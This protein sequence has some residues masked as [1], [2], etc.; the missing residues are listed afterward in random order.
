[1]STLV[2]RRRRD[3]F[4]D[5]DAL[6]RTA[7][8]PVTRS[9]GFSPAAEVSRDGEDAV[10]RIELPGLDAERDITV[11]VDRNRLVVRGERRDERS[12]DADG[13][14]VREVRYGAFRRSFSLPE[15]VTGDDVT[16]TYDAGV[17]SVRV[18][19]A[20]AGTK[21]QRIPV[22][23]SETVAETGPAESAEEEQAA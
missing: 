12:E 6:F 19:G 22:S 7:L 4:A 10:V 1:M 16:A 17:L 13:R 2:L 11:E 8:A 15:H 23:G 5:F 20:Y 3:P 18:T 21:P 9:M 14:A